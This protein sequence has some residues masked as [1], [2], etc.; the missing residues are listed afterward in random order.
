MPSRLRN[1]PRP[2][3]LQK[4]PLQNRRNRRLPAFPPVVRRCLCPPTL[5]P[6]I[7]QTPVPSATNPT[8]AVLRREDMEGIARLAAEH[9]LVVL[10][11]EIYSELTYDRE[12]ISIASL[13][14]M[15]E[16]TIFLHGFSKAWAMTGFRIGY[17][18]ASP[19]LTEAMMKIHQYTMLCAPILAQDAAIEAL[20]SGLPSA[21]RMKQ[22]YNRRRRYIHRELND[23]GLSCHMPDGAF[24][25]FPSSQ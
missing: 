3:P 19:E 20:R 16:R 2:R 6:R 1:R 12:R 11:D 13:P 14:G 17:A 15:K 23:M 21:E 7:D 10:A 4:L 25:A 8:G 22:E 9:D 5:Q 18:C 24:Y